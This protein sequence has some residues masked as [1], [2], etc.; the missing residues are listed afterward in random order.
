MKRIA[1]LFALIPALAFSACSEPGPSQTN[2]EENTESTETE[3]V[4]EVVEVPTIDAGLAIGATAPLAAKFQTGDGEKTLETVLEDGPA[5]LVF[6]RSVEWCPFCQTQLKGIDA[7]VSDLQQRGYNLYGV[8]YD[9]VESQDRF[10]KNQ[11]LEYTMLSDEGSK[12]IDAFELRDPQYTEGKAVGVPYASII[13][14]DKDGKIV[15][16]SVSGDF[17]KRPTNDQ[18]LAIVDAI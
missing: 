1:S 16:K 13:V 9:S 8:S 14:I 18:L 4:D 6:T 17:K 11:M 10:S 12:A 3:T 15:A 5:I 2:S 7:I